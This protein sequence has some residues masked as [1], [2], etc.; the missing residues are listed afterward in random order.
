MILHNRLGPVRIKSKEGIKSNKGN[1]N[2]SFFYPI[3]INKLIIY[4]NPKLYTSTL[5]IS[6]TSEKLISPQS[7][8]HLLYFFVVKKPILQRSII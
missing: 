7:I 2:P 1:H 3:N 8:S 4:P 5:Q 6:V